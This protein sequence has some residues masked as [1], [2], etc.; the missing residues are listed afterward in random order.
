MR[1][2][3]KNEYFGKKIFSIDKMTT[4]SFIKLKNNINEIKEL[5]KRG[6]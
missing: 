4:I 3:L 6:K 2:R 1:I 5:V